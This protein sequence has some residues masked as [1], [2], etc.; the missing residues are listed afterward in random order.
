[1]KLNI[2]CCIFGNNEEV[3]RD[4]KD[5]IDNAKPISTE[6]VSWNDFLA[7]ERDEKSKKIIANLNVYKIKEKKSVEKTH[8]YS[9]S[10][11]LQFQFDP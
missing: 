9:S 5:S 6:K 3:E 1:M 11:G 8:V 4:L 7:E 10:E 2:F